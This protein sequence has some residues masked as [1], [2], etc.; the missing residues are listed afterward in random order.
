MAY[1][2]SSLTEF[3]GI[4]GNIDYIELNSSLRF[5]FYETFSSIYYRNGE[6]I[7]YEDY[8]DFLIRISFE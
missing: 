6:T 8:Y 5:I 4:T 1:M 7:K 3:F 2:F